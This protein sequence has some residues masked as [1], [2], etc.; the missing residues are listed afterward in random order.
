[1]FAE[2]LAQTHKSSMVAVSVSV[3]PYKPYMLILRAI[4][5]GSG[6]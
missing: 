3:N 1:M 5:V 6:E 4:F 2:G